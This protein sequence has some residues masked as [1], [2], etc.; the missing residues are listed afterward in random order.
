MRRLR[1]YLFY[2]LWALVTLVWGGAI[3]AMIVLPFRW[4]HR[5]ATGWGDT[6]VWLLRAIC[7][8]RWAIHGRENVPDC[9]VVLVTNHQSPWETVFMPLILRDQV[10]VL[11][12]ELMRIPFFGWAMRLLGVIAIDRGKRRQSMARVI[13][14]GSARIER[15]FSV[16]MFPEGHRF[17]PHAPLKFK[18]G[19][20]R[21]ACALGVPMLPVA[22]NAGQFWPRRGPMRA[23]EIQVWIG[24][25]IPATGKPVREINAQAESWIREMRDD[26]VA[27]EERRRV[28]ARTS[29]DRGKDKAEK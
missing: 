28:Q 12:K 26:I 16:V 20:A 5:L 24:N 25:P 18:H 23:G 21:L 8:V 9:P 11:K 17:A 1:T 14:Q 27:E 22:H 3:L 10:W 2:L 7:G 19:A 4:R 6:T 29:S 13:E 15:G